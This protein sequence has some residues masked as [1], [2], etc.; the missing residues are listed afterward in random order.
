ML[1]RWQ[2]DMRKFLVY[3]LEMKRLLLWMFLLPI[4]IAILVSAAD[5]PYLRITTADVALH[6][7]AQFPPP[8]YAFK[9]DA[10]S[11]AVFTL[12]R[13]LFYDPILSRDSTISCGSCHQQIAAFAHIDHALSHGIEGAIGK[14][15][16]PALQNLIWGQSFMWDGA[17]NHIE[18]Q[19]LAPLTNHIEMDMPLPTAL[20]KLQTSGYY[21]AAFAMAY[22]D[23][24]IS[25]ERM[26]KAL[27]QFVGLMI[28]ADSRYDRYLK[29]QDSFTTSELHGLQLFRT[30]CAACLCEPLFTDERYR[31]NGLPI[32]TALRDSGR[33]IVTGQGKD[34][35]CFKV[36]SLRNIARTYPYMHDGRFATLQQ[37][38]DHYGS[39]H[40]PS[41][42]VAREVKQIGILTPTDK[43]DLI[44]FLQT[45]TDMSFLHDRRFIEPIGQ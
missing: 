41:R 35:C 7:P 11:P 18:L 27:T 6:V 10:L 45:L 43:Q 23:T 31:D 5:N 38:V 37:V 30:H 21:P 28:T 24:I 22:G 29:L 12:G 8:V 14:R 16:V 33:Y 32:D 44:A 17:V 42:N 40:Y 2:I 1:P 9:G 36:P 20:H 3:Y 34:I 15:N 39:G 19:P 25:T 13:R 26:L 4:A